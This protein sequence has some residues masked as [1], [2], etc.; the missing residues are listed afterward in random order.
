M[1]DRED[2]LSRSVRKG[3]GSPCELPAASVANPRL[4]WAGRGADLC[5]APTASAPIAF[6]WLRI[7]HG[8]VVRVADCVVCIAC[9]F[10]LKLIHFLVATPAVEGSEQTGNCLVAREGGPID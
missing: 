8:H 6:R 10:F 3:N 2:C 9:I 7:P 5:A 1:Q 4:C